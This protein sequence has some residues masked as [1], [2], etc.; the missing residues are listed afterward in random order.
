MNGVLHFG[1]VDDP[2]DFYRKHWYT[3]QRKIRLHFLICKKWKI[4]K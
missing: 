2:V 3:E 4:N 1:D